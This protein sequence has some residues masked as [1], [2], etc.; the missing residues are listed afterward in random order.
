MITIKK[1]CG[2]CCHFY[3]HYI[4]I[5]ETYRWVNCG[6]CIYSK[7]TTRSMLGRICKNYEEREA[8][9]CQNAEQPL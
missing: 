7:P 5:R 8:A 9:S 2:D 1:T 6:H 4:R 3:Q